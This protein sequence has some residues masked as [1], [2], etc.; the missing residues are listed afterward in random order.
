MKKANPPCHQLPATSSRRSRA[1]RK[2]NAQALR[3]LSSFILHTFPPSPSAAQRRK[4]P[5]RGPRPPSGAVGC[6]PRPTGSASTGL[7][8]HF[9]SIAPRGRVAVRPR[10]S[11]LLET[12]LCFHTV[13]QKIRETLRNFDMTPSLMFRRIAFILAQVSQESQKNSANLAISRSEV[14]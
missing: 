4:P 9:F 1:A 13:F 14:L 8:P 2:R 7:R 12:F 5:S 3:A 6:A 10:A 11:A